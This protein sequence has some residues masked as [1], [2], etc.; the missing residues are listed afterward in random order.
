M[1]GYNFPDN[2]K[3]KT[4]TMF[5]VSDERLEDD[6]QLLPGNPASVVFDG[7]EQP[8]VM[9]IDFQCDLSAAGNGFHGILQKIQESLF[10]TDRIAVESRI[11]IFGL[12]NQ[13]NMAAAAV[14]P[15]G[16]L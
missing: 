13:W 14:L 6:L 1:G 4:G 10:Q 9:D 16:Y 2:G 15:E 5:F 7:N 11:R 12:Q 8:F 3:T